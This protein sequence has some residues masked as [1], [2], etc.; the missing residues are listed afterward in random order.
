MQT[1]EG[2]LSAGR[3]YFVK[4][5][6]RVKSGGQENVVRV[7]VQMEHLLLD[8]NCERPNGCDESRLR[9]LEVGMKS[10]T[11]QYNE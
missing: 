11:L 8:G 1:L 6:A 3:S 9:H 2:C 10:K 4:A 5:L 7:S